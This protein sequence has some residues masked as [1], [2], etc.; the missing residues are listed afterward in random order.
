MI[1][2]TITGLDTST[3]E[4][5]KRVR[6]DS[7]L[8]LPITRRQESGK[9]ESAGQGSAAQ[10]RCLAIQSKPAQARTSATS[11]A[12]TAKVV[13]TIWPPTIPQRIGW[14]GKRRLDHPIAIG[15]HPS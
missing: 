11:S 12:I 7:T 6:E 9:S 4:M 15:W 2:G 5:L 1:N 10:Q 14:Q 8:K 3:A 13:V